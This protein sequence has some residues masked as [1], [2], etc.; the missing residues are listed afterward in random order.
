MATGVDSRK[1]SAVESSIER[2]LADT[3]QRIRRFDVGASLLLLGAAV[4][5]YA[6]LFAGFDLAVQGA[7]AGWPLAVRW[8]GYLAFL[9]VGGVLAWQVVRRLTGHI[10]P[11][12]AARRLEETVPDAKNSVISW[13]DLRDEQIP[14]AFRKTL[15]GKAAHDLEEADPEQVVDRRPT[16]VCLSIFT[17]LLL[18]MLV[19]FAARPGQFLSLMQ[20]AFLPFYHGRL[21]S[22]IQITLLRPEG[23]DTVITEKQAVAIVA[24]IDGKVSDVNQPG[25]PALLYRRQPDEKFVVQPL[26]QDGNDHWTTRLLPDQVG[27]TGLWYKVTAGDA[28]TP[29]YQISV[30]A[31]PFVQQHEITYKYRPYLNL[32]PETIVFPNQHAATPFVK[33]HR[34][35]EVVLVVHTNRAVRQGGV[36]LVTGKAEQ[37][38][39]ATVSKDDPQAFRCAW[40]LE[41]SG[42]LFVSF[43]SIEGESYKSR[44]PF[45]VDALVD[46]KPTIA[47]TIPGVRVELPANGTLQLAGT[48]DDDFGIKDV[49]LRLELVEVEGG[50]GVPLK[51]QPY[52]PET[53]LDLD[54]KGMFPVHLD[55]LDLIKLD[56]LRSILDEPVVLRPGAVVRY[57]LE[58]T[59]NSDYPIK[60]GNV[61]QSLPFEVKILPP[62][63][64]EKQQQAR[65]KAQSEQKQHNA[66]QNKSLAKEKQDRQDQQ[67]AGGPDEQQV[68]KLEKELNEAVKK[69]QPSP[70]SGDKGEAKGN[71]PDRAQNK[72]GPG[73]NG[74]A[75]GAPPPAQKDQQPG[76]P[77]QAGKSKDAPAPKGDKSPPGQSKDA[78]PP[79]ETKGGNPGDNQPGAGAQNDP[80]KGSKKEGA[81]DSPGNG[82][83]QGKDDG[84][85]AGSSEKSAQGKGA[86]AETKPSNED[87]QAKGDGSGKDAPSAQSKPGGGDPKPPS[88][89]QP[90]QGSAKA[91]DASQPAASKGQGPPPDKKSAEPS[92]KGAGEKGPGEVIGA[93]KESGKTPAK[94]AQEGPGFARGDEQMPPEGK[95][96]EPTAQDVEHLKDLLQRND[97]IRDLAAKALTQMSKE[98]PD[99]KVR[100][101]AKDALDKAGTKTVPSDD[102]SNATDP[103]TAGN[104][105]PP[106]GKTGDP[107]PGDP[108]IGK[109]PP[110]AGNT[111]SSTEVPGNGP[112]STGKTPNPGTGVGDDGNADP[113]RKDLARL[114]GN[115][116]L[117]DFI[118]RAT[119]EYR[120]KAGIT[121]E[122]WQRLLARAAEYDALL[123]KLHKQTQG[124]TARD[125]RGT[126]GQFSGVGS[127]PLQGAQ[128]AVDPSDSGRAAAPAELLD[129]LERF[130]NPA[131]PKR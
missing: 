63:D 58:A 26:Q 23:G 116:Q 77:N 94:S 104:Q 118:K 16:W 13:L 88:G 123:R 49:T 76:D 126:P 25:A 95:T 111:G 44:I 108:K 102:P 60:T 6:L 48:V 12:Y 91:E 121:P 47:L 122:E 92:A 70:S 8:L 107:G 19:L 127:S 46:A 27:S 101:L 35:T 11:Y 80:M 45:P 109:T 120:A 9:G 29:I 39:P 115:L 106:N 103:K 20:R 131:S 96:R 21:V 10:N 100:D 82:E 38:L 85:G 42:D 22:A 93:G 41:Q 78:G 113:V 128:G 2:Q 7:D 79:D 86:G 67:S 71:E 64:K 73:K 114:G 98:A 105:K 1:P 57:W 54:G 65:A 99:P 81:K 40:T 68:N 110:K 83:G 112:G 62:Q 3:C 28:E 34:G 15:G 89:G 69:N 90:P 30:R 87:A 84:S 66:Q 17:V 61:G 72:P 53:S 32:P 18:G 119:P 97:N 24:Q 124:K 4:W 59:D 55:Y 31:Q 33:R 75:D 43:T 117:E 50:K 37:E 36:R 129:A 130:R 56:E 51:A 52:R 74:G 125:G 14:V 5:G